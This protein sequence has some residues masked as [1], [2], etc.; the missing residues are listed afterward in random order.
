VSLNIDGT[1]GADT[2]C[3]YAFRSIAARPVDVARFIDDV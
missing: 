1:A 2:A 3:R